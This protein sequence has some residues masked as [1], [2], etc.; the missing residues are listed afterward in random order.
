MNMFIRVQLKFAGF[1]RFY[2]LIRENAQ[3]RQ[4]CVETD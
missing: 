2:K 3:H 4:I 1:Q